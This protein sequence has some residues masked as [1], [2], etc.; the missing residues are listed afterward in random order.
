[1]DTVSL[2]EGE[3]KLL[4]RAVGVLSTID[5]DGY[6]HAVPITVNVDGTG[7]LCNTG[8]TTHKMS[9]MRRDSRV[10][11]CVIGEPKWCIL[12]QGDATLEPAE[13]GR[14]WIRIHPAR[15]VSW[16][17]PGEPAGG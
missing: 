6:P 3:R 13:P 15:K 8:T 11:V 10:S 2:T 9:N 5:V 16:G 17:I 14:S 12:I 1:M 7:L 4:H